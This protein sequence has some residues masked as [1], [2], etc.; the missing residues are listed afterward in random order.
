MSEFVLKDG[1]TALSVALQ[2]GHDDVASV[3][4]GH[5]TSSKLKLPQIHIATK[6]GDL[7]AVALLLRRNEDNINTTSKV[8]IV[9]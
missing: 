8:L 3:L 9:F 2:Q 7:R 1:F 4:L 6:K 5:G